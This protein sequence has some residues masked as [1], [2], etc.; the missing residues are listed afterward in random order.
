MGG[1]FRGPGR[2]EGKG[3]G[4]G[5]FRGPGP[6]NVFSRTTPGKEHYISNRTLTLYPPTS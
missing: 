2:R 6:P 1:K 4:E 3:V 5:K